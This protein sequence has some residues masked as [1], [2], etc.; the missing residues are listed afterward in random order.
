[1]PTATSLKEIEDNPNT[2]WTVINLNHQKIGDQGA[3]ALAECLK[4]HSQ[5]QL[6]SLHT[7]Q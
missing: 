1:M 5:L 3:I 2:K 4:N 7:N 6:L